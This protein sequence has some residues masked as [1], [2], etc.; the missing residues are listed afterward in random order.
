MPQK[1]GREEAIRR[2][3]EALAEELGKEAWSG[4][5]FAAGRVPGSGAAASPAPSPGVESVESRCSRLGLPLPSGGAIEFPLFG[6]TARFDLSTLDLTGPSGIELPQAD[7]ILFYHYF[8]NPG[9][10]APGGDLISFREITGGSF[11]WEPFRSRTCV[12]LA[13]K[14][15]DD[16]AG[17]R[18]ALDRF[19][20]SE[21]ELGDFGAR[22]HGMG[23]LFL[24]LVLYAAEEGLESE[25]IVLF[26]PAMKRA[27]GAE[28]AAAF[29]SR[30]CLGLL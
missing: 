19:E 24:S 27:F 6:S 30:I 20:W 8:L 1:E 15:G 9:S 14:Y 16:V 18:R 11:Y 10:V 3:K 26:D 17:L 25:I 23:S 28:D 12:P 29:A 21:L 7:R 5:G 22:V 4:I 2:A 13:K